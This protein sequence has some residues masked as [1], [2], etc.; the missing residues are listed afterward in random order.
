MLVYYSNNI[1]GQ[2]EAEELGVNI[3]ALVI[4]MILAV[5]HVLLEFIQLYLEAMACRTIFSNYFVICFN[6]RLGWTPFIKNMNEIV[7]VDD[8]TKVKD[9]ELVFDYDQITYSNRCLYV[10]VPFK[11]STVALNSLR[12]TV[13]HLPVMDRRITLKLGACMCG[14]SGDEYIETILMCAPKANLQIYS[15][16]AKSQLYPPMQLYQPPT[17]STVEIVKNWTKIIRPTILFYEQFF[18][19]AGMNKSKY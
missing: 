11:F 19:M 17:G 2:Q 16:D 4:S 6:G 14:L 18:Q 13:S 8:F 7:N 5:L 10:Q 15:A 1:E 3:A 9:K 12:K